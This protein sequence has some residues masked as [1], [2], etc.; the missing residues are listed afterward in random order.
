MNIKIKMNNND[1]QFK[2]IRTRVQNVGGITHAETSHTNRFC[3]HIRR[4]HTLYMSAHTLAPTRYI[5]SVSGGTPS[6]VS[7]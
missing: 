4:R 3:V 6:R 2:N 5:M 1:I 7:E